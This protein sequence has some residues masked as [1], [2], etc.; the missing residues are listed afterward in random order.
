MPACVI[1]SA[2]V[3]IN[4]G[5]TEGLV[6]EIADV[7]PFAGIVPGDDFDEVWFQIKDLAHADVEVGF[8]SAIPVVAGVEVLELEG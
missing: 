6:P 7:V 1:E 8:T 4:V 2:G 5:V 3:F